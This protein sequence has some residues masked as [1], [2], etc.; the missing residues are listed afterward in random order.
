MDV[1]PVVPA[2]E[3]LPVQAPALPARSRQPAVCSTQPRLRCSPAGLQPQL[4]LLPLLLWLWLLHLEQLLPLQ[5]AG[6]EKHNT[7]TLYWIHRDMYLFHFMVH[8]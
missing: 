1:L 4:L 6:L 8:R 2:V 5:L 7:H 3:Q